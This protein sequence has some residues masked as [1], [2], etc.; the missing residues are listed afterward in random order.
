VHT[1]LAR[2]GG[3]VGVAQVEGSWGEKMPKGAR[4]KL[5]RKSGLREST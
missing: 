3:L 2:L 5:T 1:Y 4:P